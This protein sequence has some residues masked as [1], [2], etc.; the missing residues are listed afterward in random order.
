MRI[1]NCL[2]R[3]LIPNV[4]G[5][6]C[7]AVQS[8]VE[9]PLFSDMLLEREEELW[10]SSAGEHTPAECETGA[11]L[12]DRAGN[13]RRCCRHW[14]RLLS[15]KLHAKEFAQRAEVRVARLLWKGADL[16]AFPSELLNDNVVIK[17]KFGWSSRQVIPV[18]AGVNMFTGSP[19]SASAL[20]AWAGSLL[21]D[22]RFRNTSFFAEELLVGAG[23]GPA[24]Q[25]DYKLFCFGYDVAFIQIIDRVGGTSSWYTRTWDRVPDQMHTLFLN[26]KTHPRPQRL[27]EMIDISRRL[28]RRY[29][30]PFVRC[31]LYS[32][33]DGVYFGELTHAPNAGRSRKLFTPFANR[34]LGR[35]WEEALNTGLR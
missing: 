33:V 11:I 7:Y 22:P 5:S 12:F 13:V 9:G 24:V 30:Y 6:A 19:V 32:C 28:S 15:N 16:E 26:G 4:I 2:N 31:D 17:S 35:L 8:R 1:P 34:V 29:E 23:N 14:Q 27:E 25:T 10:T 20:R 18:R 21:A 3:G